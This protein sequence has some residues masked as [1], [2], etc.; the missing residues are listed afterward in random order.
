MK[1][2]L[3]TYTLLFIFVFKINAQLI[4]TLPWCPDGATWVYERG[5]YLYKITYQYDT[6]VETDSSKFFKI[7]RATKEIGGTNFISPYQYFSN[8]V[9]K[10]NND[11]IYF[12]WVKPNEPNEWL[13]IY[14]FIA[15]EG[16]KYYTTNHYFNATCVLP[17]SSIISYDTILTQLQERILIKR[18]SLGLGGP[19]NASYIYPRILPK[20]GG[21]Y[22]AFPSYEALHLEC[23]ESSPSVNWLNTERLLCYK[24]NI[25]GALNFNNTNFA[26][27]CDDYYTSLN[28]QKLSNTKG[29]NFYP[30]PFRDYIYVY[31]LPQNCEVQII[32]LLGRLIYHKKSIENIDKVNTR[33]FKDGVYFIHIISENQTIFSKKLIKN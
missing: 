19:L 20:I 16:Q 33:N 28:N 18:S 31:D 12:Y 27:N 10:E 13:F 3:T 32:D 30:N 5:S 23:F 8:M 15:E 29:I 17:D 14:D 24:D 22:S 7:E 4:D 25:R 21:Y 6:I 26:Y 2:F 11:S 9:L 1:R